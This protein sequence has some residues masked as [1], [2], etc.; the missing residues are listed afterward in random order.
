MM[1]RIKMILGYDLNH[2]P[3]YGFGYSY[4][5]MMSKLEKLCPC[6]VL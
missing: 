5:I 3:S 6:S 1:V 4:G 2:F